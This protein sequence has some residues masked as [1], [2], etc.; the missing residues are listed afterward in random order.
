MEKRENCFDLLRLF[1]AFAVLIGHSVEHIKIPFLWHGFHSRYWFYDGV[2]LF[3]ILSGYLVYRSCEKCNE[4]CQ[5]ITAFYKNRLL[6]VV[7]AVYFYFIIV[8][9]YLLAIGYLNF[10][11]LYQ[12]S[13]SSLYIEKED[14]F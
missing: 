2:P 14:R 3:Y 6:R 8:V 12:K 10:Y 4:D 5:S 9:I 13:S 1:A 11:N 7:P